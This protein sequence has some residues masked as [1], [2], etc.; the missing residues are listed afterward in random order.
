MISSDKR[1]EFGAGGAETWAAWGKAHALLAKALHA[2][3][4]TKT[5]SGHGIQMEQPKLVVDAVRDVVKR[6]RK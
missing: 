1:F 5:N 6:I 3:H 2:K 4:I